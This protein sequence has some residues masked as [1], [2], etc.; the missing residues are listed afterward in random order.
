MLLDL[1]KKTLL[2]RYFLTLSIVLPQTELFI[3]LKKHYSKSFF[4]FFVSSVLMSMDHFNRDF[5]INLM[6]LW[7]FF[8]TNPWLN[9]YI[10]FPICVINF[11]WLHQLCLFHSKTVN[12][13]K[14]RVDC[15]NIEYQLQKYIFHYFFYCNFL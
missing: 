15:Q 5:R 10:R 13:Y 9:A 12:H 8:K 6:P 4:T 14:A 1:F 3:S 11:F 7:I 2:Y